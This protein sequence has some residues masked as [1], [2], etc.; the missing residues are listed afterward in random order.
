MSNPSC[1]CDFCQEPFEILLRKARK[2]DLVASY[3]TCPS[4]RHVY[5]VSVTDKELRA[6]IR[7]F[8][9]FLSKVDRKRRL[10]ELIQAH[11]ADIASGEGWRIEA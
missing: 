4:C 7:G 11:Y 6:S 9:P 3:F 5:V 1:R 8:P 10:D 2:K